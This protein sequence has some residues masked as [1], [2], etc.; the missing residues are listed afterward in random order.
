VAKN[1]AVPERDPF[2]E[3]IAERVVTRMCETAGVKRLAAILSEGSA[4]EPAFVR[5]DQS[6][7]SSTQPGVLHNRGPPLVEESAAVFTVEQFCKW[8][9]ISRSTLYQ[10][11]EAGT[12]PQHFHAGTARRISRQAA[13]EWLLEREREAAGAITHQAAG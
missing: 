7:P 9:S 11:W 1:S 3:A 4:G 13:R 5:E 8:A 10:M 2:I 6:L 12:G